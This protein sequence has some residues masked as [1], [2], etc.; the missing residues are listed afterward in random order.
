MRNF[1]V[2]YVANISGGAKGYYEATLSCESF[3]S[4]KGIVRELVKK[5]YSTINESTIIFTNIIELSK[6]D[7]DNW[8]E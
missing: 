7:Y 1:L 8:N 6:E 4:R 3:P 2:L 5:N